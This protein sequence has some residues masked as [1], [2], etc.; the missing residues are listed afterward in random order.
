[1]LVKTYGYYVHFV[2]QDL[3]L[4]D[5]VPCRKVVH[6]PLGVCL[7]K[8]NRVEYIPLEQPKQY[9]EPKDIGAQAYLTKQERDECE[10]F[11][12]EYQQAL[13][14]VVYDGWVIDENTDEIISI[15]RVY[16]GIKFY[17]NGNIIM[18]EGIHN[19][20]LKTREDMVGF[21]MKDN[22]YKKYFNN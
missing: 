11:D 1:M 21:D 20:K 4:A 6:K 12:K 8:D 13:D 2:A 15:G 7:D 14:R 19:K 3:T 16:T 5:F 18:F 10:T 9:S 17:N 22:W